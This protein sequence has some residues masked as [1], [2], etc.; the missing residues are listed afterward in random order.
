MTLMTSTGIFD[1]NVTTSPTLAPTTVGAV[2]CVDHLDSSC[3]FHLDSEALW[4]AIWVVSL[5][6]FLCLPFCATKPRRRLCWR[7]I[8]ERRWISDDTEDD[9]YTA[10]VRQQ[11]ERRRQQVQEQQRQFR[12][13]RTQEDEIREQFLVQCMEHFTMV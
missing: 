11:Q 10:A 2:T 12:T 9:W 1:G 3:D 8:T 6:I 4:T 13:S 5:I 7:R